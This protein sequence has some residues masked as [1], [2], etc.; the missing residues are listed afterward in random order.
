MK[1]ATLEKQDQDAQ[2]LD[3]Q[4]HK[5]DVFRG[6]NDSAGAIVKVR[7]VG[8]ATLGENSSTI[9]LSLKTFLKDKFYLLPEHHRYS[10]ADF[11]ILTR[12][13]TRIPGRKFFWH[14]IGDAHHM[15]G[16]NAGLLEM[17]FDVFGPEKIYMDLRSIRPE[18][19][20]KNME[21]KSA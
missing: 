6:A 7:S 3:G 14:R 18:E 11:A 1:L 13:D 20:T 12:E 4:L 8:S 21:N 16:L 2:Q 15:K 5:F 9:H 10:D 19:E 17:Q